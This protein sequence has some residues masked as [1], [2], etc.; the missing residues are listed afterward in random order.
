[1]RSLDEI[2]SI[3]YALSSQR[4]FYNLILKG[5]IVYMRTSEVATMCCKLIIDQAHPP[6]SRQELLLHSG[7]DIV[8][9]A[10]HDDKI[11]KATR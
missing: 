4:F 11:V 1:M 8:K 7:L 5:V 2:K 6:P 9:D 3:C 10:T